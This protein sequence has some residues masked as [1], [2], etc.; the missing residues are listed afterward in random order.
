M[1]QKIIKRVNNLTAEQQKQ[2]LDFLQNLPNGGERGYPRKRTRLGID[3]AGGNRV[4]QSDTRDISATGVFINTTGRLDPAGTVQVVFSLP[5][6]EKPFKLQGEITRIEKN[7]IAIRFRE[8]SPY[9]N[10][11]L[12][13]AIWG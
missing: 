6:Y 10:Q 12:D 2:V 5:K 11:I 3:I 8:V 4:I 9:F 7:G 1:L 13:D